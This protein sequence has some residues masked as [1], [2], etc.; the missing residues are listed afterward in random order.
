MLICKQVIDFANA[1]SLRV[2]QHQIINVLVA[3]LHPNIKMGSVPKEG[4]PQ[5][6][7][8]SP[9]P[10]GNPRIARGVSAPTPL[11][12]FFYVL[13]PPPYRGLKHKREMS[14]YLCGNLHSQ[15]RVVVVLSH[16]GYTTC[17][18]N[19]QQ[20]RHLHGLSYL[21]SYTQ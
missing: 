1:F 13:Q 19:S 7:A 10:E 9:I 5:R 4:K 8:H 18:L 11:I 21:Q 2:Y 12:F 15:G 3:K 16:L 17:N 20:R 14:G 6:V